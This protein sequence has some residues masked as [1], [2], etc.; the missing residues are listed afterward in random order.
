MSIGVIFIVSTVVNIW[1][2][3]NNQ[4]FSFF[5]FAIVLSLIGFGK[6][7]HLFS[8]RYV[9]TI[10]PFMILTSPIYYRNNVFKIPLTIIGNALGFL[11]LYSYFF[12]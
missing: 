10:V 5:A 12:R 7:T 4:T 1:K 9:S 6:I 11:S 8:S 2:N 3:K